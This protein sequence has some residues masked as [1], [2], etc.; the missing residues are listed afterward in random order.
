MHAVVFA[1]AVGLSEEQVAATATA[2]AGG[3]A[4]SE[5]DA[6][7]IAAADALHD[8]DTL[9]DELWAK[10][11]VRFERDQLI[12]LIVIAGWYRLISCVINAL[13]I[14]LEPWAARFPRA[15]EFVR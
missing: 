6:Q 5:A 3:A 8:A 15:A 13:A 9:P 1:A 11:A 12:E 4:W 2:R 10:L 14:E 7:L